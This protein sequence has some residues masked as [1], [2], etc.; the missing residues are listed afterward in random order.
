MKSRIDVLLKNGAAPENIINEI[1][2][3]AITEVGSKY[4]KKEFFLPQLISGA[5][6]MS[7]GTALLEPLLSAQF[8]ASS[9]REKVIIAT[10]KGDIHDIGKNIVAVI[11]RNYGFEVI[12]LGK[13]VPAETII[14]C[15]VKEQV[16][17]I[18]LS[19]LMTTTMNAMREVINLARSR[20][21]DD[22]KFIVGGAV[23][24]RNFADEIGAAYGKTPLDTMRHAKSFL[25]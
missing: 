18:C 5:E 24:D 3:P 19:A 11:L 15:A 8:D 22:L 7:R 6:A 16:K 13:D 23:I 4:E 20:K 17:V 12:D 14:D 10:V 1:L 9:V 21:L 25:A 2:I